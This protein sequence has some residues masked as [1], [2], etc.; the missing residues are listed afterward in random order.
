M[1]DQVKASIIIPVYNA[2]NTIRRAIDSAVNQTTDEP[3][4]VILINDGS[5]DGSAAILDAYASRYAYVRVVHQANQGITR[6][7][8]NGI[9]A[10]RGEYVFWV[11]ADDYA[12]KHLLAKTLPLLES[13]ADVV[14]YGTQ[15]FCENGGRADNRIWKNISDVAYWKQQALN[16]KLSTIWT[17]G[18]RRAFWEG[19]TS[20]SEVARSA[21]DGYMTIRIFDK[22]R[23][24]RVIPDIL[25]YHLVDSPFSICHTFNGKRYLGNAFLWYYRLKCS[26]TAYLENVEHCA[27]RAMSGYIKAYAMD[28][29]IHDLTEEDK[30]NIIKVLRDLKRY[31]IS[32][33]IRDKLL[34]WAILHNQLWLCRIYARHKNSKT[35]QM[36]QKMQK[37]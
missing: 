36:N 37:D 7:R 5:K 11:D 15:C 12:D 23:V 24:F 27:A 1:D 34:G 30:K 31:S 3:Y 8:E 6:T 26:E 19:E 13:G 25:Y 10:A 16:A 22:A 28:T 29:V 2:Q 4:E 9:R 14:I 32:G 35:Q 21:A 33:R 20:P 17:Y 18:T